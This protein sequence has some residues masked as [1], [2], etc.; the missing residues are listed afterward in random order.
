MIGM[1]LYY[2]RRLP[3]RVSALSS[4]STFTRSLQVCRSVTTSNNAR[5]FRRT[6]IVMM[7]EGPEVRTL[8]DQLQPGVGLRLCDINF[9]SGRYTKHGKPKGFE[10]F[11]QTITNN[12]G[13]NGIPV[14]YV[15][16]WNAKGKFIWLTL[17]NGLGQSNTNINN[18]DYLRSIWI[19]LG[20]SGRFVSDAFNQEN[21]DDGS[22]HKQARWYFEFLNEDVEGH[23][24]K[25][26]YYYDTRN[27]GTLRFS[28]SKQE[29]EAK[30]DSLGPDILD[31]DITQEI[32]LKIMSRQRQTTNLCKFL[33]NQ[34]KIAGVGNYILSEVLYRS[35]LD[36]FS[37]LQEIT[38]EQRKKL[39]N[40]IIETSRASYLKQ[41]MT[42]KGGSYKDI[43]GKE[44]QFAFTLQ[45]YGREVCPK[46]RK[47][48][49]D[50]QGP[51]GR[52]IWYVEDQLI[53]IFRT[54]V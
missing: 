27:F 43:N 32:F 1:S 30:I 48:I 2:F 31:D 15:T 49:R 20:M 52:T 5:P 53:I 44:G 50:T 42:R 28:L 22:T 25:R 17:D 36:P 26:I 14:D 23:K 47:I 12:E 29:L 45:C 21:N 41:G 11:K 34:S 8:V 54:K 35:N 18:A 6:N 37:S 9:V 51:H 10:D 19:T 3:A 24:L 40:N 33:M 38:T 46:G 7:P 4:S 16:S 13:C 39:Y